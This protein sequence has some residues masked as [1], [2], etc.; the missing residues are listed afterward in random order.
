MST[1]VMIY[2][3][4]SEQK[5]FGSFRA[6]DKINFEVRR[7]EVV[8]LLGPNGAGK[9]TTMR[10]LTLLPLPHRR[11]RADPRAR[12]VSDEPLKVRESLGYLPQRAALPRDERA[13]VPPLA[14][15][16]SA[17]ST[18]R[19]SR[20]ARGT[21]SRS[22]ASRRCWG[23][24]SATCR[25][26]TGSASVSRRPSSTAGPILDL[27]EPTSD[28]GSRTRRRSS[29]STWKQIGKERTVLLSTHNLNE[30][31]QAVCPRDHHLEGADLRRR[32][33]ARRDPRQERQGP[34]R[35]PRSRTAPATTA[36]AGN[37]SRRRHGDRE[38]ARG[39]SRGSRRSTISPPTKARAH[40]YELAAMTRTA[41]LLARSCSR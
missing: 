11:N 24:K 37:R 1:D 5:S 41:D 29:S 13:R 23:R 22:A 7:G 19:P 28:L 35:R 26:V 16:T 33:S 40:A 31:E 34:L 8:G 17:S 12:R 32:R 10:I 15:A 39:R 2:N 21:S 36:T 38:R 20:S 30:V 9:S 18:T 4:R 25:T 14:P 6:V 3:E 27:D